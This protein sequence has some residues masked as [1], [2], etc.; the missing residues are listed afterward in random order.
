MG[1]RALH[2]K[3]LPAA[4]A[5]APIRAYRKLI[6]P[7]L[8]PRCKYYPTCSS[9]AEQAIRELGLIRGTILAAWRVMRCNPLSH[10]GV[11]ELSDRRLFRAASLRSQR[12]GGCTA[13][14]EPPQAETGAA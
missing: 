10:G 6:S 4:L 3:R 8:P 12:E 2:V 5:L 7:A 1:A 14:P 11:D 9:Y 13:H